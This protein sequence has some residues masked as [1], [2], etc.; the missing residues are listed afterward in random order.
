MIYFMW[1]SLSLL[2]SN[3]CGFGVCFRLIWDVLV[4]TAILNILWSRNNIVILLNF[5]SI[6]MLLSFKLLTAGIIEFT[7]VIIMVYQSAII[8]LFLVNSLHLSNL[9]WI[10]V[11]GQLSFL[12]SWKDRPV[13]QRSVTNF[14]ICS[15]LDL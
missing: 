1:E 7:I 10:L 2:S 12:G 8:I 6:L 11:W 14:L 13:L 3:S 15:G 4:I 9:F 5:L